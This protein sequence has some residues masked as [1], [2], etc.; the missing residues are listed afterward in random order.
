M[1]TTLVVA[2]ALVFATT[3]SACGGGVP[4]ACADLAREVGIPLMAYLD[5]A[6]TGL[7][8]EEVDAELDARSDL[9]VDEILVEAEQYGLRLTAPSAQ[10]VTDLSAALD[11]ARDAGCTLEQLRLPTAD[12]LEELSRSPLFRESDDLTAVIDGLRLNAE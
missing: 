1:N 7:N 10:G 5:R 3:S 6:P 8:A 11:A 2:S 12:R 4:A 9:D